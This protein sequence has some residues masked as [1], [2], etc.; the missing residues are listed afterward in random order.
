MMTDILDCH[1]T[2][3]IP[4]PNSN[5]QKEN[6]VLNSPE[7]KDDKKIVIPLI[8]LV[9]PTLHVEQHISRPNSP[10]NLDYIN[11]VSPQETK[12]MYRVKVFH[13]KIIVNN[14]GMFR[15]ETPP[16]E[17]ELSKSAPIK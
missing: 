3:P 9:S 15:D 11:A 6:N 8:R 12:M 16:Y 13:P 14:I 7:G 1:T 4:I 10:N 17:G 2:Q 5:Q